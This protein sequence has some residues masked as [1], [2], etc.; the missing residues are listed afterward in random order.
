MNNK[1]EEWLGKKSRKVK[2]RRDNERNKRKRS[3]PTRKSGKGQ[4]VMG[5]V[6]QT[7]LLVHHPKENTE[8]NR[9]R[10]QN[11]IKFSFTVL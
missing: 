5:K 7:Y 2:K 4:V 3:M 8:K 11:T 9:I 6:C 10:L 1:K